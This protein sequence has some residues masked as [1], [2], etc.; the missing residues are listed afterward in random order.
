[1]K[2]TEKRKQNAPED[3]ADLKKKNALKENPTRRQGLLGE[4]GHV[5]P[6]QETTVVHATSADI[7]TKMF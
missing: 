4:A 3:V 6:I 5:A 2:R 1:M 7:K